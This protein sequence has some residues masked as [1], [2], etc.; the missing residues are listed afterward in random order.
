MTAT[1]LTEEIRKEVLNYLLENPFQ[2]SSNEIDNDTIIKMFN[3]ENDE[4]TEMFCA[5]DDEIENELFE[6]IKYKFNLTDL[7]T[8]CEISLM[9][10]IRGNMRVSFVKWLS[11]IKVPLQISLI[12]NYDCVGTE[13]TDG[14]DINN[15]Y[16][17]DCVKALNLEPQTLKNATN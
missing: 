9:A 16:I 12:S 10:L 7:D 6:T 2:Y 11:S 17:G 3:D 14:F 13:V 4:Y 1:L 5:I 8:E 15:T